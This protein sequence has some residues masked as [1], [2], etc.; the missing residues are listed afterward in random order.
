MI[1]L[2]G[3]NTITGGGTG[4]TYVHGIFNAHGYGATPGGL[5]TITAED[6]ASLSINMSSAGTGVIVNGISG[7]VSQRVND[8]GVIISGKADV[9]ITAV[10]ASSVFGIRTAEQYATPPVDD[11][12]SILDDAS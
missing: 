12:V 7:K 3:V 9:S 1:K 8:G 11:K 4:T 5:I 2:V 10:G 6:I